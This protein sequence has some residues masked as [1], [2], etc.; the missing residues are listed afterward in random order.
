MDLCLKSISKSELLKIVMLSL[1]DY[2]L[3]NKQKYIFLKPKNQEEFYFDEREEPYQ[4]GS[5]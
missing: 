5:E 4:L 1:F 3:S 2:Q